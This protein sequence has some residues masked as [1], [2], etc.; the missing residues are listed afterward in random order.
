MTWCNSTMDIFAAGQNHFLYVAR[1]LCSMCI[2]AVPAFPMHFHGHIPLHYVQAVRAAENSVNKLPRHYPRR[3]C[4]ARVLYIVGSV[5]LSVCLLLDISLL[6]CSF[7]SQRI[8]PTRTVFSETAPLRSQSAKMPICKYTTDG[9][10][11]HGLIDPRALCTSEAPEDATQGV[12]RLS[13]AIQQCVARAGKRPAKTKPSP[14]ISGT[15]H[16]FTYACASQCAEGL[17]F[18][19]FHSFLTG[20]QYM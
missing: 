14:S 18:S 5:C 2:S 7:V 11:Y 8:R 1:S 6:E 19:A 17:H 4:A 16:A 15:A 13:H 3:A 9:T 12:Y 20:V 10:A